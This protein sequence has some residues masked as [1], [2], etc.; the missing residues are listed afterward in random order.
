MKW[1]WAQ[2]LA[3][4][5]KHTEGRA[6]RH[7]TWFIVCATH[8]ELLVVLDLAVLQSGPCEVL[9]SGPRF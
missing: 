3:A 2:A 1:R 5:V 7:Q 6:H 8:W 9:V 4:R